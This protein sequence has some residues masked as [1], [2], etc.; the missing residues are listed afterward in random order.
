VIANHSSEYIQFDQPDV[1]VEAIREVIS[2][3]TA[4]AHR[5]NPQRVTGI[6]G[7]TPSFP[8]WL[9]NM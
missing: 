3:K 8:D 2:K 7:P 4:A 9:P 1:A 5:T 6:G